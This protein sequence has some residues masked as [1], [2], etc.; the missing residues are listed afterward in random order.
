MLVE[1]CPG[2]N[3]SIRRVQNSRP[4]GLAQDDRMPRLPLISGPRQRGR[5]RTVSE[6]TANHALP[7]V[8]QVDK[9]HD[10]G[11]HIIW[12]RGNPCP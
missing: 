2:A 10:D 12:E 1:V 4:V 9:C 11:R 8:G 7:D 6:D 3:I 5:R